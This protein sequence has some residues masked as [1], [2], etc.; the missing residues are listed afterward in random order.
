[1][2]SHYHFKR[3]H[4][5]KR[6]WLFMRL[7]NKLLIYLRVTAVCMGLFLRIEFSR[8]EYLELW[9]SIENTVIFEWCRL[10]HLIINSKSNDFGLYL[11][12]WT[13]LSHLMTSSLRS[14]KNA[15]VIQCGSNVEHSGIPY[16]STTKFRSHFY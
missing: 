5:N 10:F 7:F 11:Y 13:H 15:Y 2:I 14:A 6:C 12:K 8:Y 9:F 3:A 1:M 16:C 4:V